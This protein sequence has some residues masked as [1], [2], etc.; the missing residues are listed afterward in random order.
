MTFSTI[1]TLSPT[2]KYFEFTFHSQ[3]TEA[4]YK[5]YI[6]HDPDISSG[7]FIWDYYSSGEL[8]CNFSRHNLLRWNSNIIVLYRDYLHTQRLQNP[9]SSG[10]SPTSFAQSV[11]F[12]DG[13]AWSFDLSTFFQYELVMEESPLCQYLSTTFVNPPIR[14]KYYQFANLPPSSCSCSHPST[15]GKYASCSFY[16][17]NSNC[18][19]SISSNTVLTTK[20]I[21][22]N[23][24]SSSIHFELQH[25]LTDQMNHVFLIYNVTDS[26]VLTKLKYTSDLD[27]DQIYT[28]ALSVF[29]SYL[30]AYQNDSYTVS[31]FIKQDTPISDKDIPKSSYIQSLLG[32]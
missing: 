5:V 6:N 2:I 20:K 9:D 4:A 21:D 17:N 13:Y 19:L 24:T 18:S 14:S 29:N 22:I 30:E 7:Q 3:N 31:D 16:G 11:A 8:Y 23:N 15:D 32:V 26:C 25:T 27:Y 10:Q 1:E 28:E 12:R